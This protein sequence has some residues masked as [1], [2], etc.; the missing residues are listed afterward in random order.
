[1]AE[2]RGEASVGDLLG[3]LARDTS[4]LV[5]QEVQLASTEMTAKAKSLAE[6]AALIGVGGALAQAGFLVLML[7][8]MAALYP[9]LPLWAS[10]LILGAIVMATG[11]ALVQKGASA[12]RDLDPLPERMLG[13]FRRDGLLA[14]EQAR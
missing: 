4:T 5:R 6:N 2:I 8:L 7:S 12:L 14:K 1:M 10:A 13:T 9:A 11:Y 3:S